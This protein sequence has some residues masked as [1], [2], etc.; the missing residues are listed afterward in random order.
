[1]PHPSAIFEPVGTVGEIGEPCGSSS[2]FGSRPW[3]STGAQDW[4][5]AQAALERLAELV[6]RAQAL[7]AL[8]TRIVT[9]RA[10]PPAH[11]WDGV[12]QFDTK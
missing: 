4:D 8:L 10:R 7:L 5:A 12:W 9:L 6:G 2:R 1:V 11:P 3:H